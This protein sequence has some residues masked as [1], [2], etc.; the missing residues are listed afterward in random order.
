MLRFNIFFSTILL[1]IFFS[2]CSLKS[3]ENSYVTYFSE[4]NTDCAIIYQNDE[5]ILVSPCYIKDKELVINTS[6]QYRT[7]IIGIKKHI[8]HFDK[9]TVKT[10]DDLD[11]YICK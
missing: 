9:M 10:Q 3:E 1:I 4:N 6:Y 8:V 7:K 2:G 5:C 11:D